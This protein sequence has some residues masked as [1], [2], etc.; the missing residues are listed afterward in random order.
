LTEIE[1]RRSP[2]VHELADAGCVAPDAEADLLLAA[3]AEG[4]GPIEELVARRVRGE[5]LAWIVGHVA[6]CGLRIR[7][8][9][10]V[11]VPRPHTEA[12]ARRAA[13]LLPPAGAGVDLCTGSGAVAAVMLDAHPAAT[14]VGTDV[15][16]TAIACARSN[17]VD[18]LLG[19]LDEPIPTAI[20]GHVDVV[21][22]V[23]P[24]VPTEELHLLP[25]DVLANEP[26]LAIDG[27]PG[28][29][30]ALRRAAEA[31]ARCLRSGGSVLLEIGGDQAA[32]MREVL[33]EVGFVGITV[34]S[35]ED[36]LDRSIEA[37]LGS[38]FRGRADQGR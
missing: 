25:R 11:F 24:Y 23:V 34:H 10:G 17:G 2:I 3:A 12:M 5:P 9:R 7:V 29:T 36:G 33:R 38:A 22:A 19:D 1:E 15:D 14:V 27:G 26:R 6:F 8:D 16:P 31:A 37:R 21:S 32:V 18:A 35:D 4:V 30:A 20:R 13:A 28:G